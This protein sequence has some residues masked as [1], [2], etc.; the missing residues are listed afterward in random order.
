MFLRRKIAKHLP[1]VVK[2][3]IF[4]NLTVSADKTLEGF[5]I[6]DKKLNILRLGKQLHINPTEPS[7]FIKFEEIDKF[8]TKMIIFS[9]D[10]TKISETKYYGDNVELKLYQKDGNHSSFF[11]DQISNLQKSLAS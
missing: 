3:H 7:P 8:N 5:I 10:G 11:I 1:I 4:D 9:K 2:Y 6:H